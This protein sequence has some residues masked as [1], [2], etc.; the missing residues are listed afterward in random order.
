VVAVEV[1]KG[2]GQLGHDKP[3]LLLS[4]DLHLAQVAEEI[5]S[6]NEVHNEDYFL[7]GMETEFHFHKKWI[8]EL[9]TLLR[10]S[11]L[12]TVIKRSFSS[13]VLR[14]RSSA[15]TVPFWMHFMA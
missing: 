6:S 3:H 5:A 1:P 10:F 15:R 13:L 8:V 4:E 11:W 2:E 12:L 14:K 9:H 7:L